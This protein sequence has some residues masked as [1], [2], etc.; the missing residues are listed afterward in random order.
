MKHLQRANHVKKKLAKIND[1]NLK[2]KWKLKKSYLQQ[3]YNC[4]NKQKQSK[5][6]R[7]NSTSP[8]LSRANKSCHLNNTQTPKKK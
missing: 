6:K 2:T 3:L 8:I 4:Q 5:Q 7:N 1:N